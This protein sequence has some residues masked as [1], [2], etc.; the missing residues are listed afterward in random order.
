[1][2]KSDKL[3]Y[4]F[5]IETFDGCAH[6][7]FFTYAENHKKA[8]QNLQKNSSDYKNLVN[9]DSDLTIKIIKLKP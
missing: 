6:L 7:N 5:Q 1:M 9:K 2:K 8:L 3:K 4:Y